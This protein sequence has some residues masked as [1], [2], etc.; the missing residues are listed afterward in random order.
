MSHNFKKPSCMYMWWSVLLNWLK[1]AFWRCW[2]SGWISIEWFELFTIM[3]R[4]NLQ[5]LCSVYLSSISRY[6]W[7]FNLSSAW[8]YLTRF[9]VLTTFAEN[10][11][12]II[13]NIW[14]DSTWQSAG[15][16]RI[17][18]FGD[19]NEATVDFLKQTGLCNQYYKINIIKTHFSRYV[20]NIN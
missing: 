8:S 19:Y 5:S 20:F 3:F 4:D 15:V 18:T 2:M 17:T 16:Y 11:S 14:L 6:F 13:S 10:K 7:M 12:A 1:Q 9:P